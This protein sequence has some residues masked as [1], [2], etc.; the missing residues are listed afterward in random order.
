MQ[1]KNLVFN[2]FI[3][4]IFFIALI[5]LMGKNDNERNI[6]YVKISGQSVKVE[7]A[8]TP[9]E[10]ERG[11][12]GRSGLKEN[13]GMLFVFPK[14]GN[15]PFWMKGMNFPIDI[16]WLD[17]ERKI[18]YIKKD[19]RPELYPE[20]YGPDVSKAYAKYVLEVSSGF[21]ENNNLKVGDKVEFLY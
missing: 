7:L 8:L 20:S 3:V 15:Y 21:S 13:K 10:R 4:I 18:I 12:S 11:L 17:E 16:I 5:F 19:A 9:I 1:N 14:S 2:F 6:K